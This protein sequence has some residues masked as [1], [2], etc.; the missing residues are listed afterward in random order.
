MITIGYSTRKHNPDFFSYLEKSCG[1]IKNIQIVEKINDGEKSLSQVYNEIIEE[2]KNDIIL[3]CHDDIYIDTSN[4]VNKL[5]RHFTESDYG[6]LGVA[7][8]TDIPSSGK[9][10]EDN[11]KMVGIVN[12]EHQGKKWESKYCKSWGKDITQVCLIDGLFIAFDKTKIKNKFNESVEGFHFYDVTFATENYLSHVKIGVIYDIR[13]THKSIGQT[14]EK[15]EENRIKYAEQFKNE[16]PIKY[17]PEFKNKIKLD[18]TTD[19]FKFNLVINTSDNI[20]SCYSLINS[21]NSFGLKNLKISLIVK[22]EQLDNYKPLE[23]E[24]VKI[25]EGYFDELIKNLSVLKWEENFI[26]SNDQIIIFTHENC[27][28]SNNIFN[29]SAKI[30]K[31][32]QGSFGCMFPLSLNEDGTIF[33]SLF[34]LGLRKNKISITLKDTGSYYN[35]NQGFRQHVLG[36]LSDVFV[37]T[38][39]NL[40]KNDWFDIGYESNLSFND[41]AIKCFLNK[42]SIFVD[43]DSTTTQV[44]F[45][46]LSKYNNDLNKLMS[47]IY[48]NENTKNLI[49]V[50]EN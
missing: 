10:W 8:T 39:N 50:Y 23:S 34:A 48:Q 7:G 19:K 42:K 11:T 33:S 2:S 12:H 41:F 1:K 46:D 6:I 14:N 22:S 9:W 16:L 28:M 44:S 37:T 47:F 21:V 18:S 24:N 17:V 29:S 43:S 40:V 31:N 13:V 35:I 4:W 38:Y 49:P 27:L 5:L 25:F 26:N 30:Y 45:S 15:W 32:N 36:N 20:N 3:L